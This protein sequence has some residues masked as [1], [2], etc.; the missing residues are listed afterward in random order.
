MDTVE[1]IVTLAPTEQT[2]T[3]ARR[4]RRI[5]PFVLVGI[6]ALMIATIVTAAFVQVPYFAIAPGDARP[7]N[8]RISVTGAPVYEPEGST[9]FVTVGVPH[10]T[11]LGAAI[12][13]LDPNTDVIP[14][15]RILGTQTPAEN[16]Q[17]NLQLMSY[18]KD[19]ATY[20]ALKELGFPVQVRDGGVAIDSL[21][22]VRADDGSCKT[23]SPADAVLDEKDL[24]TGIAG[25]PV[26]LSEDIASALA[27]KKPGDSV[28]VTFVRNGEPKTGEV[29]LTASGDGSRTI[30]G[31]IPNPSPPDTIQFTFPVTVNINS[32]QVGGPSAGLAFTLALL[33]ELTPGELTGG[34]KV[35]ATGTIDPAGNVGDIGGIRQKTIAVER[36]GAKLFLVPKNLEAI[37][38]KQA[39]GT[40]LQVK[41]VETL[42]DALEALNQV[43]GN[44]LALGTPGAQVPAS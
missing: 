35:A 31:I 28:E 19:F 14:Q 12:G 15:E 21:C 8:T 7:V 39:Q 17:Q 30:L 22:L 6:A 42:Q 10:L 38:Q 37:A 3:P 2:S 44:A 5:W 24:I 9:L 18:S 16:R 36:T 34:I 25:R 11:A 32:G 23:A 13:W 26:N 29:Q 27:G 40:G 33:D 20:V 43:G 41:G 1:P 4:R